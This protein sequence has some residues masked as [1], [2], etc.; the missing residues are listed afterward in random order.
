MSYNC[1]SIKQLLDICP[2]DISKITTK[3]RGL[4]KM[5]PLELN[6]RLSEKYQANLFIKREDLQLPRSFKIRGAYHKILNLSE[7]FKEID[8]DSNNNKNN[9]KKE[10]VCAS[11]GNHAQGVALSCK[12]LNIPC[13]IFLPEKT[14]LQKINRIKHFSNENCQ[15]IFYGT[16]FNECLKKSIEYANSNDFLFIH[17]YNDYDIIRGQAT[18]ADEI[19]TKMKPDMIISAIGGG[20]LI[21]GISCYAKKMDKNCQIIGVEPDTCPSMK[22]SLLNNEI[23]NYPVQDN[24][25]DGATVSEVGDIT[26]AIAK[27]LVDDIISLPTGKVCE[28]LLEL[29]TEDGIISEPAGALSISALDRLDIKGKNVVCILSG[30]N[31][32]ISRYPEI[33]NRALSYKNL[34]H[35]YL[36]E[37]AQRPGELKTFINNILGRNDDIIRFEYIKKTNIACGNVLLGIELEKATNKE[38]IEENLNKQGFKYMKLNDNDSLYHYLI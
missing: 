23:L 36:I 27:Q 34:K 37:F 21:S 10:I 18:V 12:H 13:T 30:G 35:Y 2:T 20:G 28:T 5:T 24:F 32:D 16:S 31:N 6:E 14:P 7:E 1:K 38:I 8:N 9:N 33:I 11:A 29:Y 17:P 3:I 4:V 22:T 26:Y 15:L 19:Y 25:V